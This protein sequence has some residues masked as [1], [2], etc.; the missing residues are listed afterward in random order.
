M[1]ISLMKP[2]VVDDREIMVA[3]A[4]PNWESVQ[5][6]WQNSGFFQNILE[7]FECMS[8]Q[9]RR[10][11]AKKAEK[12][13]KMLKLINEILNDQQE[14]KKNGR[15]IDAE[16]QREFNTDVLKIAIWDHFFEGSPILLAAQPNQELVTPT[17]H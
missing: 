12:Q 14:L 9:A 4:T 15:I 13:R 3:V 11:F 16:P 17:L 10:K 8:R 2:I 5:A 7:E 1:T 6:V